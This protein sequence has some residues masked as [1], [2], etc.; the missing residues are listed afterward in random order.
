MATM[1]K[2]KY[3]S[4]NKDFKLRQPLCC[5][6]PMDYG[7]FLHKSH[8][9]KLMFTLDV[10]FMNYIFITGLCLTAPCFCVIIMLFPNPI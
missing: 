3:F 2:C 8:T 9:E 4:V 6:V 5:V 1:T 10:T 7:P